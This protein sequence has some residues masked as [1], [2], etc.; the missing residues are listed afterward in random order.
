M[1]A[2]AVATIRW[3]LAFVYSRVRGVEMLEPATTIRVDPSRVAW[4]EN[5]D[6]ITIEVSET[7]AAYGLAGTGRLIWRLLLDGHSVGQVTRILADRYEEAADQ[8]ESDVRWLTGRLLE[9]GVLAIGDATPPP[10][11]P[12]PAERRPYELA[13]LSVYGRAVDV[14]DDTEIEFE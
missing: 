11:P 6:E 10:V 4:H 13:E 1:T 5:D 3:P 7:G 12:A 8:L 9:E 2:P 14:E